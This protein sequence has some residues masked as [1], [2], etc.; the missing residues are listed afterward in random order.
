VG[1]PEPQTKFKSTAGNYF[2]A[3]TACAVSLLLGVRDHKGWATRQVREETLEACLL[4]ALGE[5]A[6]A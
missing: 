3:I 6:C 5:T 1:H 2:A 4:E